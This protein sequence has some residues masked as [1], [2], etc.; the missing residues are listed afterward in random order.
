MR[1]CPSKPAS[2]STPESVCG[3]RRARRLALEDEVVLQVA[4]DLEELGER[5]LV[6]DLGHRVR[7]HVLGVGEERHD[8][9]VDREVA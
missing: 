9:L 2:I 3:V 7:Q 4:R 1:P 8:V 5:D 6:H